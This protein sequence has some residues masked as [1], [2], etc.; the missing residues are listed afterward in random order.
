VLCATKKSTDEHKQGCR[1]SDE[2]RVS[3]LLAHDA[4]RDEQVGQRCRGSEDGIEKHPP[5]RRPNDR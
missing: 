5:P 3:A 2:R 4:E 1:R